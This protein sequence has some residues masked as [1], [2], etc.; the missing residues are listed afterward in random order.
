MGVWADKAAA[1]NRRLTTR[2]ETNS[3]LPLIDLCHPEY[4]TQI[5]F[6]GYLL[7]IRM[8][9]KTLGNLIGKKDLGNL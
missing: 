4:T 6:F 2:R 7:D 5:R 8:G 1:I 3:T 9:Q